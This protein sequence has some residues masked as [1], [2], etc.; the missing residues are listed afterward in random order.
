[1][2]LSFSCSGG[3]HGTESQSPSCIRAVQ[4]GM[5]YENLQQTKKCATLHDKIQTNEHHV[6]P[7]A[8]S[9]E[10]LVP[11]KAERD[12]W[13]GTK[14]NKPSEKSKTKRTKWMGCKR[15][16]GTRQEMVHSKLN[17]QTMETR[18]GPHTWGYTV[19]T[20]WVPGQH[21]DLLALSFT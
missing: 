20:R 3:W 11:R 15:R 17:V 4:E 6:T 21:T 18:H 8:T 14:T 9:D 19:V 2:K 12:A 7:V 16:K 5:L 10:R 13:W 1:M